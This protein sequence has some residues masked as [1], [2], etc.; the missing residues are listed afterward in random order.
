MNSKPFFLFFFVLVTLVTFVSASD[1]CYVNQNCTWWAYNSGVNAPNVNM[2]IID[3]D[4]SPVVTNVPMS[5]VTSETFKYVSVLNKSGNYIGSAVFYNSSGIVGRSAQ[6]LQVRTLEIGANTPTNNMSSIAMIFGVAVFCFVLIVV[7]LSL[8]KEHMIWKIFTLIFVIFTLGIV[9]KG[10]VD[11]Y[12]NC[13]QVVSGI[14]TNADGSIAYEYSEVCS[15]SSLSTGQSF[16]RS[17]RIL[18]WVFSAY[19][20][21]FF[22]LR[23]IGGIDGA[24]KILS[25]LLNAG[26]R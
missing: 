18:I 13:N 10:S 21:I 11:A 23:A 16:L 8:D 1:G 26:K 24:R 5:S 17:F 7:A 2:S 4:G 6:S 19:A 25:R 15:P 12:Q 22:L 9:V 14:T 3:P 20:A